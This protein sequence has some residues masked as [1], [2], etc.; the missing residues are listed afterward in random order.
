MD[1]RPDGQVSLLIADS[2]SGVISFDMVMPSRGLVMVKDWGVACYAVR[3]GG[4]GITALRLVSR[5]YVFIWSPN[6]GRER[7]PK[8]LTKGQG[9]WP[10]GRKCGLCHRVGPVI[11]GIALTPLKAKHTQANSSRYEAAS[12]AALTVCP[13]TFYRKFAGR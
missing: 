6:A 12:K 7:C 13:R 5:V 4:K 9:E 2:V 8:G 10:H 1:L 11:A 3:D